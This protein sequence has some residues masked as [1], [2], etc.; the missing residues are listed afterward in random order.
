MVKHTTSIL[1]KGLS[2]S[3]RNLS[4]DEEH[5][6]N[7]WP[8]LKAKLLKNTLQE[9][10]DYLRHK[11]SDSVSFRFESIALKSQNMLNKFAEMSACF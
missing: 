8:D 1:S 4:L 3:N 2:H 10:S 5:S 7:S 9:T 11:Q 6:C